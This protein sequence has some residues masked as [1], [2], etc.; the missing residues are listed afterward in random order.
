[1]ERARAAEESLRPGRMPMKTALPTASNRR[2]NVWQGLKRWVGMSGAYVALGSFPFC[3]K[4]GGPVGLLGAGVIGALAAGA[5][6]LLGRAT[7]N[8]AA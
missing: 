6:R 3:G 4:A 2:R 7:E 5:L 1:M 8:C